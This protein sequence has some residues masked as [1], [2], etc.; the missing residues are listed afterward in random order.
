MAVDPP[1]RGTLGNYVNNSAGIYILVEAEHG[2][3]DRQIR[4]LEDLGILLSGNSP[5]AN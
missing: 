3:L 5:A 4:M 2:H 1:D